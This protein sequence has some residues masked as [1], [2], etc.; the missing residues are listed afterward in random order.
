MPEPAGRSERASSRS[1]SNPMSKAKDRWTVASSCSIGLAGIPDHGPGRNVGTV[2]RRPGLDR[3]VPPPLRRAC[4]VPA[5]GDGAT[6]ESA[7]EA[8]GV[9]VA[10]ARVLGQ[11]AE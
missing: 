5:V 9:L 3:P 6:G 4:L 7:L 1:I 2:V 8:L 11:A 10:G